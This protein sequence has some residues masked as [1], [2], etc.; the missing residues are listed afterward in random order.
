M[1]TVQ[2]LLG[3]SSISMTMRYAHVADDDLDRAV[4]SLDT[5]SDKLRQP[6][7]NKEKAEVVS[8]G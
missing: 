1:R 6:D 7:G 5:Q 3:H 4:A 8:F 2:L